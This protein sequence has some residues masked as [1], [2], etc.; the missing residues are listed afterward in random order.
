VNKLLIA[1]CLMSAGCKQGLGERCQASS[2]CSTGLVCNQASQ[3]C[4]NPGQSGGI[5]AEVP[6]IIDAAPDAPPDSAID[7]AIDAPP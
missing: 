5:D 2:D 3:V 6:I 1:I 7:A 4:A